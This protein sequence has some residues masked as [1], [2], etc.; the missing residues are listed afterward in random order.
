MKRNSLFSLLKYT[1][2]SAAILVLMVLPSCE[3]FVDTNLPSDRL[4]ADIAL[5]SDKSLVAALSGAYASIQNISASTVRLTNLF[6]DEM[7]ISNAAGSDLQ[8]QENTYDETVDYQF[9][10][11][12]YKAIYNTNLI[13]EFL[14][15]PNAISPA[16]AVQ[17]KG[18]CKF[19]R[20]YCYYRLAGFYGNPPL[21]LTSDVTISNTVG[22]TPSAQ[23]YEAI[24]QDLREAKNLLPVNYPSADRVRAN[25]YAVSAL[26][27]RVYLLQHDWINAE[28]EATAVID[29][30][31]VYNMPIDLNEVFIKDSPETIWQ[32]WRLEGN[33]AFATS[34]IPTSTANIFY[35]L[36][37]GLVNAFDPAD[38]RKTNWMKAGTGAA[39]T[40]YYPYKYK[41][42]GT[43]TGTAT[44]YEVMFRLAEQYLIRAE[45][46]AQQAGK[47]GDGLADL[48]IVHQRSNTM[49]LA[50]ADQDDL[51]LKIENERRLELMT[52]EGLRWLDL[53]RTGRTAFWLSPIKPTF[54]AKSVLVPYSTTILLANPNLKQNP[55]Y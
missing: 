24:V 51:L 9:F 52:E 21:V 33:T 4:P 54:T 18:E 30:T 7:L 1:V 37:P 43:T 20:A 45:A 38:K 15:K 34:F 17:V 40:T 25:K 53:N 10:P 12:F 35:Q 36:R 32:L 39:S 31:A 23:I 42:R 28:L 26:L 13:I 41:Q 19:L 29:A 16:V 14:E 3:K 11:N 44:E 55:D 47:L 22:N 48:N 2:S 49:A 46:R 5:N 27:A 50:S 6:S 8:A